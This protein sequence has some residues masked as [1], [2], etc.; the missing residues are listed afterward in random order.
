MKKKV[1]S[2]LRKNDLEKKHRECTHLV[3]T[4]PRLNVHDLPH[5]CVGELSHEREGYRSLGQ[6][7]MRPAAGFQKGPANMGKRALQSGGVPRSGSFFC[8]VWSGRLV[9][10]PSATAG[11]GVVILELSMIV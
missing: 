2:I 5:G 4:L 8:I 11:C 7:T 10:F 6:A 1:S 3:T 9:G